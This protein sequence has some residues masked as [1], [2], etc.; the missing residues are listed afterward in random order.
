[1]DTVGPSKL[2]SV[3]KIFLTGLLVLVATEKVS[4]LNL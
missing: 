3:Q 1:M 4:S 2:P